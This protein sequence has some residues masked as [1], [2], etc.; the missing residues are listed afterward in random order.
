MCGY[1]SCYGMELY[2]I[3]CTLKYIC[4]KIL[5]ISLALRM[6][7]A[8][9]VVLHMASKTVLWTYCTVIGKKA[10]LFA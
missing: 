2:F 1:L 3:I 8:I 10:G 7:F 9:S 5:H 6:N 4:I